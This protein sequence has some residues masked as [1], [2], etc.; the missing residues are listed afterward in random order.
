MGIFGLPL[1]TIGKIAAGIGNTLSFAAVLVMPLISKKDGKQHIHH[2]IVATYDDAV[3]AIMQS[4]M[5][6]SDRSKAVTLVPKD[7]T[8]TLYKAIINVI[9]SDMLSSDKIETIQHICE[10]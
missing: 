3:M 2:N 10:N 9:E 1:S 6:S 5:L 8:S 4:S 7:A